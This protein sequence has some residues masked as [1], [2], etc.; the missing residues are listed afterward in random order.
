MMR[1]IL[2]ALVLIVMLAGTAL[3]NDPKDYIVA[4]AGTKALLFYYNYTTGN[5]AYANG[6]L[7]G[8]DTNLTANVGVFR[9]VYY[10]QMASL[11]YAANLILPFGSLALDGKDV[12]GVQMATTQ[13]GDPIFAFG[14]WPVANS[15]SK[16]WLGVFE[17]ITP[18]IGQY[19]NDR[20]LNM[21][22]NRWAFK[23]EVGL[24][25]GLGNSNFHWDL[26]AN[27]EFYT[28]NTDY[29]STHLSLQ[30]NPLFSAETHLTYNI[31]KTVGISADYFYRN[32]GE[33][34][35]AGVSNNDKQ[36]DHTAGLTLTFGLTPS[37]QILIKY[38]NQFKT[39]NG[40]K[41]DTLGVRFAYFF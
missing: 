23:T 18:P 6:K 12:G 1:K 10:G 7:V 8:K 33:T 27:V 36:N 2:F 40:I 38:Y 30:K 11:P 26:T 9:G 24:A 34:N 4:P 13:Y 32:G 5:E 14:V 15:A 21:G 35:V 37:S 31:A 16:T 28:N 20:A 29:S 25:Q 19:N 39:E 22:S 17:Y 3:A 41:G